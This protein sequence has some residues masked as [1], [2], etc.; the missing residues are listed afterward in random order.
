[1]DTEDLIFTAIYAK[2]SKQSG[3]FYDLKQ[4]EEN[5]STI[6]NSLR[7]F[8]KN[9]TPKLIDNQRYN[10][11]LI[12][13]PSILNNNPFSLEVKKVTPLIEANSKLPPTPIINKHTTDIGNK[14]KEEEK[15]ILT[16][17]RMKPYCTKDTSN[18]IDSINL[19]EKR[20]QEQETIE[21][22]SNT[23]D[24][25]NSSIFNQL[26]NIL[27]LISDKNETSKPV[28]Q[29]INTL[30]TKIK[31]NG[32]PLNDFIY[33]KISFGKDTLYR[34]L[35]VSEILNIKNHSGVIDCI[36]EKFAPLNQE[37]LRNTIFKTKELRH[38]DILKKIDWNS[39]I[40]Y[41]PYQTIFLLLYKRYFNISLQTIKFTFDK[42]WNIKGDKKN[43]ITY[44]IEFLTLTQELDLSHILKHYKFIGWS[45]KDCVDKRWAIPEENLPIWIENW[46]HENPEQR[47]PFIC[48]LGFHSTD[49][50]IVTFRR[51]LINPHSNPKRVRKLYQQSL[52]FKQVLWNTITWLSQFGSEVIT[53][54]IDIIRK[55]ENQ[56]PI[57]FNQ[58]TIV[59]P[60]IDN[61]DKENSYTYKLEA[62]SR[63]ETLY[64][65]PKELES[66]AKLYTTI[67]AETETETFKITDTFCNQLS[68]YLKKEIIKVD[69]LIDLDIL[70]KNSIPWNAPFYQKWFYKKKYPIYIYQG[71]KIPYKTTYKN[72]IIQRYSSGYRTCINGEFF[73]SKNLKDKVLGVLRYI[74]PKEALQNLK[75]WHYLTLINPSLLDN[76]YFQS[77]PIIENLIK[78]R[79]GFSLEQQR[80]NKLRPLCQAIYH[81]HHLG[82]DLTHLNRAGA[83]LTNI[84][85]ITGNTI[86]CL[87]QYAKEN[88]L[89]LAPEHW[90]ILSVPN[91]TLLI[92]FPHNRPRLYSSQEDLLKDTY[93]KHIQI[94][95]PKPETTEDMNEILTKI[96]FSKKIIIEPD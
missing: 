70:K 16:K 57:N 68:N 94:T 37:K 43:L 95:I 49:S 74:F 32:A 20:I 91:I 45:F 19:L 55:I 14:I 2:T 84:T 8:H 56:R 36:I 47:I 3:Y 52:P 90:H 28:E 72:L 17:N 1:M 23:N 61:I 6:Y 10:I 79:L 4:G 75:E 33:N 7:I 15:N 39:R 96:K 42:Y 59:I 63:H 88:T 85:T 87:V 89:Y 78:E 65:L 64:V 66:A 62:V 27:N 41:T 76:L 35:Q 34:E 24:Y 25:S 83:F 77:N 26:S 86:K 92:I 31:I 93:L 21:L 44:Y 22:F 69:Q 80:D 54:N 13:N 58:K 82:Y 73:I 29:L 38:E 50:I 46:V 81:L 18:Y 53:K 67:K 60:L 71:N 9:K 51:S 12:R 11:E 48:K 40:F 30:R 5:K